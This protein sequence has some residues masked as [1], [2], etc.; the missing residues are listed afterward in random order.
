MGPFYIVQREGARLFPSDVGL[1]LLNFS[2][3]LSLHIFYETLMRTHARDY[4]RMG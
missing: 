1:T 2:S 3:K 4:V